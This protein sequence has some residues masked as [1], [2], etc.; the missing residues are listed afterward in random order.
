MYICWFSEQRPLKLLI[1]S[2]M[3]FTFLESLFNS[4]LYDPHQSLDFFLSHEHV[5]SG[6]CMHEGLYVFDMHIELSY[7]G[8]CKTLLMYI[9]VIEHDVQT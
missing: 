7:I 1:G 5:K 3:G 6:S 8:T 2:V 9:L 4:K